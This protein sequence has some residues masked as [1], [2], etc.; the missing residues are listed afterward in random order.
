[1]CISIKKY[2]KTIYRIVVQA[3][4][5]Y[6]AERWTKTEHRFGHM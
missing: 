6:T 1:M 4:A 3:N 5:N 2:D